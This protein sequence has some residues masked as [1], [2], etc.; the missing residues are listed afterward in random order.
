MGNIEMLID[1]IRLAIMNNQ[2]RVTL[3]E[4]D[5]ERYLTIWVHDAGG[6]A[7][8]AALQKVRF[9]EPYTW[10]TLGAIASK[11]GADLRYVVIDESKENTLQAKAILEREGFIEVSC[12]PS[13]ALVGAMRAEAPIFVDGA[14]LTKSG[15]TPGEHYPIVN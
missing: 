6:D 7:I 10:N 1:S 8:G 14:I 13:E 3:K 5:G 9:S 4:K 15:I 11:L 2:R 12:T